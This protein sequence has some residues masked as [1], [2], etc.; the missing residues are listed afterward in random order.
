[1]EKQDAYVKLKS[2]K[3]SGGDLNTFVADHENLVRLAGWSLEGD[4]SIEAFHEGLTPGLK[5]AILRRDNLP[6][7]IYEW[8]TAACKE[9]TKWALLKSSGLTKGGGTSRQDRWRTALKG[10][11]TKNKDPDAMEVNNIRLNPLTP[12]DRKKLMS[13]GRCFRCRQQGHM[14]RA[15]PK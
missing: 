11:Q 7:D 10:N 4:G 8:R 3:M 9:Q 15:C 1:M 6:T 12:E 5:K 2:L 13:E 14:S